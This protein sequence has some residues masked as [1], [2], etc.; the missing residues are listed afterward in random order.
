MSAPDLTRRPQQD[1]RQRVGRHHGERASALHA[2][3]Q[4][5]V[6][7]DRAGRGRVLQQHA[8]HRVVGLESAMIAGHHLDT[9]RPGARLHHLERLRMTTT[10][11][12]E[13][14]ALTARRR[15]ADRHRFGGRGPLVEQRGV[16]HRQTGQVGD[17]GLEVDE[18]LEAALRDLG[19]VG[20]ICGVPGRVL[21]HV[22]LDHP[23]HDARVIAHAQAGAQHQVL[24]RDRAQPLERFGLA[25]AL[26][27]RDLAA[28][29]DRRG[30]GLI[31]QRVEGGETQR[32]EHLLDLLGAGAEVSFDEVG[33][34]GSRGGARV[35]FERRIG[36]CREGR[37]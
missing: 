14:R 2:L 35:R 28:H 8:E 25:H 11:D 13:P 36:H 23:R 32:L 27:D 15:Q 24:A 21:Q 19:L 22:A 1:E 30:N 6:V 18:R 9:E 34:A 16:G 12:E 7:V 33:Q 31:D 37:A 3:D 10:V 5:L 17:H 20:R 26:A 4:R 29:A